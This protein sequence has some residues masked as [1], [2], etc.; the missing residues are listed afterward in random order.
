MQLVKCDHLG[1]CFVFCC[2]FSLLKNILFNNSIEITRDL[3]CDFSLK[4]LRRLNI[5]MSNII[6][7]KADYIIVAFICPVKYILKKKTLFE[8]NWNSFSRN[9][10]HAQDFISTT[11]AAFS[12]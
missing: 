5:T 6:Q 11:A 9:F 8:A 2:F 12:P 3:A 7:L 1:F 4:D 10:S